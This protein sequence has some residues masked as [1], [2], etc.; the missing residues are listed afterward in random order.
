MSWRPARP[1]HVLVVASGEAVE[2]ATFGWSRAFGALVAFGL[3][4]SILPLE[5]A[6]APRRPMAAGPAPCGEMT[7]SLAEEVL[8][9]APAR[10]T[11]IP[12]LQELWE[13]MLAIELVEHALCCVGRRRPCPRVPASPKM[14][15]SR[16][17]EVSKPCRRRQ[18]HKPICRAFSEAL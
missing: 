9:S 2:E 12:S 18:H 5:Q 13:S 3:R 17:R 1:L 11:P 15:P 14:Y 7:S 4:R 10:A 16:T 8:R 6:D